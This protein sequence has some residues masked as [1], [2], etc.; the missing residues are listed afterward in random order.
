MGN[1][2]R[3]TAKVIRGGEER[4]R[5]QHVNLLEVGSG[6]DMLEKGREETKRRVYEID[7]SAAGLETVKTRD[8]QQ[9]LLKDLYYS[10]NRATTTQ[11]NGPLEMSKRGRDDLRKNSDKHFSWKG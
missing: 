8:S 1:T 4:G 2:I 3:R 5:R 11:K 7:S 6:T 10:I 9:S